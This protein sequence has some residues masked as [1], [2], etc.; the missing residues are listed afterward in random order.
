MLRAYVQA[1]DQL[2]EQIASAALTAQVPRLRRW[3]E[4]DPETYGSEIEMSLLRDRG[5]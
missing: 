1:V 5:D 4:D 2:G 3:D